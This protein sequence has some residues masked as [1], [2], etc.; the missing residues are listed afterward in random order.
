MLYAK[1]AVGLPVSGTFDYL[2][3]EAMARTIKPGARVWVN[4][5][6][7]RIIGYVVALAK[8]SQVKNLKP[9]LEL[10]D[11]HPLLDRKLILLTRKIADYYCCS[12]GEAIATAIPEALRKGKKGDV[13]I[14]PELH[15]GKIE[16]SPLFVEVIHDLDGRARWDT[17]LSEIRTCLKNKSSV[18][19]LLP[20]IPDALKA[21]A[22]LNEQLGVKAHLLYRKQPEELEEWLKLS[23][24]EAK[25]IVGTRSAVFAPLT[26]LGLLIIDEEENF[27]YKQDQV[28]HYHA[29]EAGIM[30]AKLEG[31]K[32]ILG[33]RAP[34]LESFY[35]SRAKGARYTLIPR[36]KEYPEI[37]II[38]TRHL[39]FA[40][41]KSKAIL[42]KLLEEALYSV[43]NEK[44]KSLL[45]LNRKGFATSAACHNCGKTLKCPRC[46]LSL[47]YHFKEDILSCHYCNFKL[48]PP[49]ICPQ[50]NAGYIKFSG[51]GT[52]KIES[53]LSRIF[54]QARIK[55]LDNKDF[56]LG[57]TDIAI[58]GSGV[59]K[60]TELD[61]DLIAVLGID[62]ALN[63]VDFRAAEKAF[64]LLAGL[65]AL[66]HKKFFIQTSF[67]AHHCFQALL[68]KEVNFFYAEELKQRRQLAFPP[69]KHLA[70][71]KLR[72]K[73]EDKVEETAL[74]LFNRLTEE[75]QGK[76]KNIEVVS[77]NPS[78]PPKLRG[79]FYWQVL[80][81]SKNALTLSVFLKNNLKGFRHSG[82]I[83]TV[84]IDPL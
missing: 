25:V 68:K 22:R 15:P 40:E 34:S 8:K 49:K 72:G 70:A 31:F 79:N 10:I 56:N 74:L 71:V 9:V 17:Y 21:R 51:T 46:N 6:N 57:D 37:K 13:S 23:S 26:N 2:V 24:P 30:R 84:D 29:R 54:P 32:L 43:L 19:I 83:V 69:Y 12:W 82:I 4:F 28:P 66:T 3:P 1:I 77:V 64:G 38:D 75:R 80:L 48:P 62:N 44:G 18:I 63:H 7:R 47:V 45:F 11:K 76:N 5:G 16:T 60:Q 52:E 14:F 65:L 36:K 33:S 42:S 27:A 67:P 55:I 53:E 81:R 59:I 41:R 61:F 39:A 20:D 58:A 78:N 35:L 73:K 50:C